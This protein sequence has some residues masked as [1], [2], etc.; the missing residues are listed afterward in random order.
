HDWLGSARRAYAFV[1]DRMP[2]KDRL[3]HAFRDGQAKAPAVSADYANMIRASISLHAATGEPDYLSQAIAWTGTLN[4]DYWHEA[5]GG[6]CMTGKDAADVIVRLHTASDDATPNA[7]AIMISNLAHLSMLTGDTSHMDRAGRIPDGF[8]ADLQRNLVSH[9]GL[10]SA[11]LDL[12]APQQI[13]IAGDSDAADTAALRQELLQRSLPNALEQVSGPG[14]ADAPSSPGLA[15]KTMIG[16]KAAAYLC[17]GP[18]CSP[19]VT[20]PKEF[21]DQLEALRSVKPLAAT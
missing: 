11:T 21:A 14:G 13:V 16:G 8:A 5:A 7:N 17:I 15:G 3:V 4:R 10:L 12:I 20:D 1:I 19:P 2:D 6:Y 18:Q 9:C